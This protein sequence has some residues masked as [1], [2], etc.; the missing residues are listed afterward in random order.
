MVSSLENASQIFKGASTWTAETLTPENWKFTFSVEYQSEIRKLDTYFNNNPVTIQKNKSNKF[1][2]P[3]CRRLLMDI[4]K[5]WL[6]D[7][8]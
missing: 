2:I 4:K 1:L 6:M 5:L 3:A 8:S 7:P